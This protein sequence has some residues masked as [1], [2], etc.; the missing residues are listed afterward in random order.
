MFSSLMLTLICTIAIHRNLHSKLLLHFKP[1]LVTFLIVAVLAHTALLFIPRTQRIAR[2]P[3]ITLNCTTSQSILRIELCP[4]L[5][6][7]ETPINHPSSINFNSN[8]QSS[9]SSFQC[10]QLLRTSTTAGY[11][12]KTNANHY[13]YLENLQS[14]IF[15]KDRSFRE[16]NYNNEFTTFSMTKCK[17]VCA[18]DF[19]NAKY[20]P[21]KEQLL[22][23][24]ERSNIQ[25]RRMQSK[26]SQA[27]N[28]Y[29]GV[30]DSEYDFFNGRSQICFRKNSDSKN[31]YTLDP[32]SVEP[33]S[34]SSFQSPSNYP[35]NI[36]NFPALN[37]TIY[38]IKQI[39][40]H[41]KIQSWQPIST[42]PQLPDLIYP[43]PSCL[44]TQNVPVFMDGQ[45]FEN[46]ICM[47][48]LENIRYSKNDGGN[49]QKSHENDNYYELNTN[50][51]HLNDYYQTN[52]DTI[53]NT[54][55][56]YRGQL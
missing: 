46:I 10:D 41:S 17:G 12:P 16:T 32:D 43:Y 9:Y 18:N 21:N 26:S 28:N 37:S 50:N 35:Y 19:L 5:I 44:F 34:M 23:Y 49:N 55:L 14:Q 29:N 33:S 7:S 6:R 8:I 3:K 36:I 40:F 1:L 47:N 22:R 27:N 48:P 24:Y 38:R 51:E 4:N 11:S 30:M 20:E 54:N 45:S 2:Y 31:C 56:I 53:C 25:N 39:R 52:C 15:Y 42:M 13:G